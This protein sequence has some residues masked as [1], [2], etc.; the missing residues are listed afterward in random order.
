MPIF[1]FLVGD[2]AQHKGFCGVLLHPRTLLWKARPHHSILIKGFIVLCMMMLS[3]LQTFQSQA[4]NRLS[5]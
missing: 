3:L 2:L 5:G 4:W 1:T